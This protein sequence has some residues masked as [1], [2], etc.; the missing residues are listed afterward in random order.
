[1]RPTH[2]LTLVTLLMTLLICAGW[3]NAQEPFDQTFRPAVPAPDGF[4]TNRTSYS[5][6]MD[7]LAPSRPEVTQDQLDRLRA[8]PLEAI[9]GAIGEYRT[10]Y[11]RGFANTRPGERLVGRALTMRFL[12]PR[13]D[14][15]R[16]ANVLAEEGNWDRR[17]Y[18]RAAEEAQPGDVVV[19]ELGGT[20]GHNLFGDMGATGIQ[21]R[22]AAGVVIDGGMRDFVGLQDD[23]FAGFPVLHRFSD[24]HTTFWLGVEYNAPVRIGG[25]TVLPGDIVVGDD[26]GVFFFPPE[27]V[28]DVLE[29]AARSEARERFQLELLLERRYRF[30]DVY[31]LSPELQAEFERTRG[32]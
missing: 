20:D 2:A 27:L 29:Y 10:N 26:G 5:A 32:R 21:M 28:D 11:V 9:F 7:V 13:P 1:M 12:P 8:I 31:P 16:A 18:A 6:I 17:Y 25:V 19:A 15:T 23:R 30:R 22:G 14:L 4:R 24:P 3:A